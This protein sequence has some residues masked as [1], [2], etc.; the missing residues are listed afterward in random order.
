MCLSITCK[1]WGNF[2]SHCMLRIINILLFINS[3][4]KTINLS[5]LPTDK[6][7]EVTYW[8]SKAT[9]TKPSSS[10]TTTVSGL[11][12]LLCWLHWAIE[13]RKSGCGE[14][15]VGERTVCEWWRYMA[16]FIPILLYPNRQKATRKHTV[17]IKVPSQGSL[18][19]SSYRSNLNCQ[20]VQLWSS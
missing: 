14:R 2:L 15:L 1:H 4:D 20:E 6:K 18:Q 5:R 16:N 9:A 10:E 12:A 7:Y 8:S 13:K 17:N 19:P 11:T 3:N